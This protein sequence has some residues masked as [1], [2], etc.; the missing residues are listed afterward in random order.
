MIRGLARRNQTFSEA[1]NK[2]LVIIS[3]IGTPLAD[4]CRPSLTI[5]IRTVVQ[6]GLTLNTTLNRPGCLSEASS[7]TGAEA[8][9]RYRRAS[10][11][12]Q[13]WTSVASGRG[14]S[15]SFLRIS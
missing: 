15:A 4:G 14:T 1:S 5:A 13:E 12:G 9:P 7:P 8:D 6:T 3:T 11:T 10:G 2:P